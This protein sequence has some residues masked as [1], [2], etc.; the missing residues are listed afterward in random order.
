[1]DIELHLLRF[2]QMD[3]GELLHSSTI[4]LT[5]GYGCFLL[6]RQDRGKLL[7]SSCRLFGIWMLFGRT[8]TIGV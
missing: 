4:L 5:Y 7:H 3:Y 8:T 2:V 6:G 1:M